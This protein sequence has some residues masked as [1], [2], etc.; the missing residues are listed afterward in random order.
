MV[1]PFKPAWEVRHRWAMSRHLALAVTAI[2]ALT[3]ASC[4]VDGESSS[5]EPAAATTEVVVTEPAV[6]EPAVTEPVVTELATTD[7]PDSTEPA[8]SEPDEPRVAGIEV[9]DDP[10]CQAFSRVFGVGGRGIHRRGTR[11][12]CGIG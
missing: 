7:A 8:S 4:G 3:V 5:S 6:T 9:D 11:C 10:V 2:L 12:T 1:A